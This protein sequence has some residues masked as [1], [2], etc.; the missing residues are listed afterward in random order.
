MSTVATAIRFEAMVL[1]GIQA[2][3]T[4]ETDSEDAAM[5]WAKSRLSPIV[6]QVTVEACAGDPS[7][8]AIRHLHADGTDTGWSCW[9]QG[10]KIAVRSID[11]LFGIG[12]P[13]T[14]T[15]VTS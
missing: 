13:H 5:E 14:R 11:V 9:Y 1:A 2:L 15:A 6:T 8:F 4:F 7:T 3:D 12:N 10:D